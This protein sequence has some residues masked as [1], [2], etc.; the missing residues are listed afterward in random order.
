VGVTAVVGGAVA[1]GA[2]GGTVAGGAVVGGAGRVVGADR[3]EVDVDLEASVVVTF[4]ERG[5]VAVDAPVVVVA[6]AAISSRCRFDSSDSEYRLV[7]LA[8]QFGSRGNA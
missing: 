1:G 7:P 3:T 5:V 8:G 2:V 4:E 6:E